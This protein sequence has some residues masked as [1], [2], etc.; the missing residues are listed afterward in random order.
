MIDGL[1]LKKH[2]DSFHCSTAWNQIQIQ[3][4]FNPGYAK[5]LQEAR[6]SFGPRPMSDWPFFGCGAALPDCEANDE[7]LVS[8]RW[9]DPMHPR[10]ILPC[11]ATTRGCQRGL[12]E[13]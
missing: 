2:D 10:N 3:A 12:Q 7:W 11:R 6:E 8:L 4:I 1:A 13:S 5:V 9:Y